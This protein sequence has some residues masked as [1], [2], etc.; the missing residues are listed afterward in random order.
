MDVDPMTHTPIELNNDATSVPDVAPA[1]N[2]TKANF[3]D[4]VTV[5]NVSVSEVPITVS[6]AMTSADVANAKM[7][8]ASDADDTYNVASD[9][10]NVNH[11]SAETNAANAANGDLTNNGCVA[12][13]AVPPLSSFPPMVPT[14]SLRIWSG[15]IF[16]KS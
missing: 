4:A 15:A 13:N 11:A 16:A 10:G 14:T 2:T 8:P 3:S 6:V 1:I 5:A 7:V 9:V 12:P